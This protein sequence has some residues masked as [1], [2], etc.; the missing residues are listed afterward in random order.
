MSDGLL[1]CIVG[2]PVQGCKYLG[3]EISVVRILEDNKT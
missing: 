3:A 1:S 2:G